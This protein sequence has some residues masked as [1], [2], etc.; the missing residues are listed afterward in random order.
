MDFDTVWHVDLPFRGARDYVHSTSISNYICGLEDG[1]WLSE[2]SITLRD[3]MTG[4]LYFGP[5]KDLPVEVKGGIVLVT[6]EGARFDIAFGDDPSHRVDRRE[7]YDE[8]AVIAETTFSEDNRLTVP[9]TG[10]MSIFDRA[11]AANKHLIETA[12]SPGVKLIASKI[13]LNPVINPRDFTL[14]LSSH[15]GHR[16][17]KT[18]IEADDV[19]IGDIVFYGK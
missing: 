2:F 14:I 12:L 9:H 18:R 11:I 1:D 8:A 6:K 16:L 15:V 17:F 4:R 19:K 3:W 7:P 10:E 5:E 13:S